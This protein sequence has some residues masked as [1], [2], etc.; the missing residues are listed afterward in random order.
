MKQIVIHSDKSDT[1][2][3]DT[4][5][6]AICEEQHL[7]NYHA[8]IAVSVTN[9]VEYALAFG[10]QTLTLSCSH[11]PKGICFAVS[12]DSHCFDGFNNNVSLLTENPASEQ[13]FLVN[14][15]P[16]A[17]KVTDEANTLQLLFAVRGISPKECA[18]RIA[19][20]EKFYQPAL[21]EA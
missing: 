1:T 9:A 4:F 11:Y 8:T 7:D 13:A 16:D 5:V 14:T 18:S 12:G 19:I 21:V 2:L 15:L 6:E 3:V 10:C 20:F 17:V